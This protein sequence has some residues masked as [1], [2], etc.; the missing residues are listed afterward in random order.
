MFFPIYVIP[1]AVLTSLLGWIGGA[2]AIL[3]VLQGTLR[4]SFLAFLLLT[5]DIARLKSEQT[6]GFSVVT[7]KIKVAWEKRKKLFEAIKAIKNL[8]K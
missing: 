3:I 1:Y 5:G 2:L 8:F 4:V 6:E 7:E